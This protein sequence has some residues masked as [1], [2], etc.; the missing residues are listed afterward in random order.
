MDKKKVV[1]LVLGIVVTVAFWVFNSQVYEL[2]FYDNDYSNAMYNYSGYGI[3]AVITIALAWGAAAL[4]YYVINSVKF[5]R[6]YHWL[7]VCA[8]VTVVTPVV[9]YLV[10]NSML[11]SQ[12][13][14]LSTQAV[15]F[16]IAN[17]F[18]APVLYTVASLAMRWWSNNCRHT[19]FPQ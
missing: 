2:V 5:A 19:P 4:F 9:C 10:N 3:I 11:E 8:V 6:W 12:G 13:L 15:D 7:A 18:W 17:F 16:E 1:Y 14:D